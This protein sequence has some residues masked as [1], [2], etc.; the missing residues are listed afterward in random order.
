[1]PLMLQNLVLAIPTLTGRKPV[2]KKGIGEK[3]GFFESLI[4]S[5]EQ[6]KVSIYISRHSALS[7]CLEQTINR[8]HCHA[9]KK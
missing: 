8:F 7:E 9:T 6:I 1:M 2:Q 4:S 5:M 3:C